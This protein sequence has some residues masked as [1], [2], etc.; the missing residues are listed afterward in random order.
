M[1][2]YALDTVEYPVETGR[3]TKNKLVLNTVLPGVALA[4]SLLVN[5]LVRKM[6]RA[7]KYS[8]SFVRSQTLAVE[9]KQELNRTSY[10]CRN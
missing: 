4:R 9:Y 7:K 8:P 2:L 3:L 1:T 5:L 10:F 6:S